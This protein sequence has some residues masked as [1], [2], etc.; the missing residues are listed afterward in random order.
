MCILG[1]S[2]ITS[3]NH[4][5]KVL[6]VLF[7][8]CHCTRLGNLFS[9]GHDVTLLPVSQSGKEECALDDW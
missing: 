7:Y 9:A 6:C 3:S 8:Q 1:A 4:Q 5:A 2:Y